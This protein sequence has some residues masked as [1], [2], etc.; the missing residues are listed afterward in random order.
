MTDS[1]SLPD[2]TESQRPRWNWNTL[3]RG[4][5][6]RSSY[7]ACVGNNGGPDIYYYADGY[8]ESVNLLINSITSG[9]GTLDTLIYP[10]CFSLRHSV[11][12][13]VKAQ[14]QDLCRLAT[15][16]EQ[17]LASANEIERVLNQHDILNLW[18]FYCRHAI[19]SDRRYRDLVTKTEPLIRCIG[20]TD[21]T[22][23][24]FRYSYSTDAQKHLTDV[25]LINVLVLREQFQVIRENL[26]TLTG[27]TDYLRRE[28]RTGTFTRRLNRED[29]MAIA[30]QLPLRQTWGMET[31]GFTEIK[32]SLKISFGIGSRELS[33]AITKIEACRDM[34]RLI[35]ISAN[36][37]GLSV[38]DLN[39]LNDFWKMAWNRNV[40]ERD[41]RDASAAVLVQPA[42]M[43]QITDIELQARKD[44]KASLASFRQW[45]TVEKLAGLQALMDSGGFIFCEEHDRRYK[46]CLAQMTEEL[47]ASP[48]GFDEEISEIWART[49]GRPGYPDRITER[50][51]RAG[52][53]DEAD[54]LSVNL[55]S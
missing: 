41:E 11:E 7:N 47:A 33:E 15:I 31:S 28:Y 54:S 22:G 1:A 37:P 39:M 45:A 4:D 3:F 38:A 49:I 35:G 6:N 23:Q 20:E 24:T 36:V 44:P 18:D 14:I 27:L 48:V 16:R 19:A 9:N 26:E 34:A 42:V 32:N 8:A 25:S 40:L 12:L 51:K 10:I 50:L 29:L 30:E 2:G 5:F 55:V 53:S 52:F 21:A 46:E 43:T 17:P 13:T